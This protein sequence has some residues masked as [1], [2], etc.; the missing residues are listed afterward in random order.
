[1]TTEQITQVLARNEQLAKRV[2]DLES[3][4]QDRATQFSAMY[5]AS[6]F[7]NAVLRAIS[8]GFT[9][10]RLGAQLRKFF[11]ATVYETPLGE[12]NYEEYYKVRQR[13]VEYLKQTRFRNQPPM[14]Q[15]IERV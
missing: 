8:F 3:E 13:Q 1:M 6:R 11:S 12:L 2:T 10:K 4:L 5:E 9:L 15:G 14:Q 7:Y